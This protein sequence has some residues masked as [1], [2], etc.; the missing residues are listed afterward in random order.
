MPGFIFQSIVIGGG[1]ATG[2]ELIEFFFQAGP[3]GGVLGLIFSGLIFG[4]VL[5]AAFEF[6]RIHKAYDYRTFCKKLMGRY[7]VAYEIAFFIL[8]MLILSVIAS[9]A[10][11]LVNSSFEIPNI[12]GTMALMLL[13]AVLTYYGGSAIK[14]TLT[15]WSILLYAV[16]TIVFILTFYYM[17][18]ELA[19]AYNEPNLNKD[20]LSSGIL[21]SG[22]N[23]AVLPA[24]LFAVV[25]H[26]TVKQTV[27]S[28]LIAG[29]LAV[30]PAI[31]FFVAL[32]SMYP[33]IESAAVPSVVLMNSLN[34]PILTLVF[35]IVIFGTFVETGAA[36]LHSV[37]ERIKSNVKDLGYQ[38]P[39]Y[40]RP[41]TSFI[42]LTIAIF[43]SSA[44]GIIDLISKGYSALT[45][46]FIFVLIIPL[47]TKGIWHSW[48][49]NK[50]AITN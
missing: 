16:Y 4:I 17:G 6:A 20:W 12:F 49:A 43:L 19:S 14:G 39:K 32:M 3:V 24:A 30:F 34:L 42:L 33:E 8:L 44:F 37:N 36:L 22:Y 7:W 23:L 38:L 47:L 26:K 25:S 28:G 2:R 21:Y 5:S 1:Y 50:S 29:L 35:Q 27:G 15:L 18:D 31:L 13:I 41:L 40:I 48:H 10:G 11:E 46:V 9:A 45:L